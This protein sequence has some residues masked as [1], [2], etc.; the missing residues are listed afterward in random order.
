[1]EF[2]TRFPRLLQGKFSTVLEFL[3]PL[4]RARKVLEIDVG[5]GKF[6]KFDVRVPGKYLNVLC[7]KFWHICI[8]LYVFVFY[9]VRLSHLNKD[10]LLTYLLTYLHY[11]STY[12]E[13]K[14][15]CATVIMLFKCSSINSCSFS[16]NICIVGL[17]KQ[18]G[19]CFEGHG[20]FWKS[21]GI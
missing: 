4:S 15:L 18:S 14:T 5:S 20:K 2:L 19:K 3:R 16:V 17:Q 11:L 7:F 12:S 13:R 9:N 1:M 8:T 10:Y 6:W 21:S